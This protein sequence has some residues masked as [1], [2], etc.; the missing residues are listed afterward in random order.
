M[1]VTA[2]IRFVEESVVNK[3]AW[4]RYSTRLFCPRRINYLIQL[5]TD[6]VAHTTDNN[7]DRWRHRLGSI[8]L[9][10]I[11]R[12]KS[13]SIYYSRQE[14]LLRIIYFGWRSGVIKYLCIW[15]FGFKQ[16]STLFTQC[17]NTDHIK[18]RVNIV[19]THGRRSWAP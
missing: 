1:I 17:P 6:R 4:I 2:T 7:K 19:S 11:S 8:L 13:P 9:G 3:S 5:R 15:I 12:T 18:K 16:V 10:N 14:Y